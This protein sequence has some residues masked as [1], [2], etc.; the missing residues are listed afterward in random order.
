MTDDYRDAK[1]KRDADARSKEAED[2][3]AILARRRHFVAAALI[4]M[5]SAACDDPSSNPFVCLEVAPVTPP[6]TPGAGPQPPDQQGPM[7]PP[8]PAAQPCLEY[9][10]PEPAPTPDEGPFP[11]EGPGA[12]PA[13]GDMRG[14]APRPCLRPRRP[15][16]PV[17]PETDPLS[18]LDQP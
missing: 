17:H 11:D 14:P 1:E 9:V 13:A 6:A 18:G 5:A 2:R 12:P 15:V 16:E 3:D 7:L 4:G 8:E 10:P